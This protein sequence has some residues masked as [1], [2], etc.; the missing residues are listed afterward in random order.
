M[1]KAKK[2]STEYSLEDFYS[3]SKQEVGAKMPL[4]IGSEDTGHYLMVKGLSARSIAQ[5][6]ID[7]Q[8]AYARLIESA[9]KID[10]KVERNVFIANEK[11][12]LND[13]LACLIVS[14]WSFSA[15]CTEAEKLKLFDENEDMS[16]LVIQL[17]A[18]SDAYLAKK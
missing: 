18:D 7:W 4:M 2:K 17:A 13:K 16:E 10:D 1:A 9:E 14:G 3:K 11:K 5:Q 12:N 6:K 8:I 15:K